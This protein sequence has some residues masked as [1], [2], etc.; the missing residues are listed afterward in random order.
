MDWSHCMQK[1]TNLTVAIG[2]LGASIHLVG[3][4]VSRFNGNSQ[5]LALIRAL[6]RNS[7]I[8]HV[9]IMS[10]L[11]KGSETMDAWKEAIPNGWEK[12]I[13]PTEMVHRIAKEG[14][15]WDQQTFYSLRK[16]DENGKKE[17]IP[18]W[19]GRAF[20]DLYAIYCRDKLPK[21]DFGL[22]FMTQGATAT[23]VEGVIMRRQDPSQ[24]R[25]QLP[26][27]RKCYAPFLHAINVLKFPWFMISTDERLTESMP[28]YECGVNFPKNVLGQWK[29]SIPWEV[30]ETYNIPNEYVVKN[31]EVEYAAVE[32][33]NLVDANIVDPGNERSIK[34]S[35]VANQSTHRND[36][37][38]QRFE[39]LKTW[40]LNDERTKDYNIYGEW[41]P[42][43]ITGYE[44]SGSKEAHRALI[45]YN[46]KYNDYA[47]IPK[48]DIIYPQFKGRVDAS[49]VDE[50]FQNTRYTVCFPV[51][52]GYLTWKYLEALSNG[53]LPFIPPFYDEQ[54]NA[55]P[56]DAIIRVKNP[57]DMHRKIE[58]FEQNPE[59]RIKLVRYYQETILKPCIDGS[60]FYPHLNRFL[61]KHNI[62]CRV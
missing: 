12:L 1:I 14:L 2:A 48:E 62:D 22:F 7:N 45:E 43:Y 26:S 47:D 30:V 34:F 57:D 25:L 24:Y 31:L 60:Y 49:V 59:Q 61:E 38:C 23:G 13:Y 39:Q 40:I 41:S 8:K 54:H 27:A 4:K 50:V 46:K 53:C 55:I 3:D 17:E 29:Y 33:L 58:Y 44:E 20:Q 42:A 11:G 18:Y 56:K 19:G 35:V 52:P 10:V 6:C 32:C 16:P 28:R 36:L 37:T 9:V 21:I 51:I 5:Y 15:K